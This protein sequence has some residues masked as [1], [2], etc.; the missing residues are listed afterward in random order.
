[1]TDLGLE[2]LRRDPRRIPQ[3]GQVRVR[4]FERDI[5]FSTCIYLKRCFV[6][7]KLRVNNPWCCL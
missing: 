6:I 7:V 3:T 5:L 4:F 2:H 1:M